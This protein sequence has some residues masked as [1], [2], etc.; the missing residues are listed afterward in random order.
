MIRYFYENVLL[1]L[2]CK[3]DIDGWCYLFG[4]LEVIE[5]FLNV[6]GC[7]YSKKFENVSFF[8]Y[9]RVIKYLGVYCYYNKDERE[10]EIFVKYREKVIFIEE[11][12]FNLESE[13]FESNKILKKKILEI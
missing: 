6:L 5:E 13:I 3:E 11:I 8:C 7:L 10:L 2:Y 1:R 4:K 9:I 12:I